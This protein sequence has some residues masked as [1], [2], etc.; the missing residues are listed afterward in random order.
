MA[1]DTLSLRDLPEDLQSRCLQA[2]RKRLLASFGPIPT[3]DQLQDVQKQLDQIVA[4]ADAA[5]KETA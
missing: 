1:I 3:S 4:D 5:A 2:I